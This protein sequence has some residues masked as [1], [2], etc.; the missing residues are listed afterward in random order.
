[1]SRLFFRAVRL[2]LA[3]VSLGLLISCG[4]ASDLTSPRAMHAA[5]E[6][7][8]M[9]AVDDYFCYASLNWDYN[10]GDLRSRI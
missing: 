1:M 9:M 3:V 4:G 6:P 10:Q 7:L 2:R 8:R 5:S